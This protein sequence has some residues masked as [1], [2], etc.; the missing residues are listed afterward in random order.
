MSAK[1]LRVAIIGYNFMG[2]A[3]SN[4]WLQASRFFDLPVRPV[5][6]VA[7][8]RDEAAVRRFADNWGWKH[9]ETDWRKAVERED[10]DIVDISLPQHLHHDVAVAAAKEGKHV[11][12]E[13]PMALSVADAEEMLAAAEAAGVV[14][15]V[16]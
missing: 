14:H 13:K 1:E 12:C 15:Y 3:H 16:N 5:L 7:C 6:Q 11:F 8:G 4:G 9:V 2:K 10:V